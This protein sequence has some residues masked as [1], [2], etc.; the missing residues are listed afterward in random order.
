VVLKRDARILEE[1][2]ASIFRLGILTLG[3]KRYAIQGTKNRNQGFD[4]LG[5]SQWL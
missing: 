1:P 4:L 2:A 3:K 5:W